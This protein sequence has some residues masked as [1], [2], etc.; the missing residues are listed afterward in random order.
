[1][2]EQRQAE[3]L[4]VRVERFK[5]LRVDACICADA[6]GKVHSHQTKPID[7]IVY[8]FDRYARV[9]QRHRCAGPDPTGIFLLRVRHRFIPHESVVA[10]LLHRHVGEGD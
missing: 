3:L 10:S 7:R 1:M 4:H 2:Q 5:P 8:R 9:L 6:A